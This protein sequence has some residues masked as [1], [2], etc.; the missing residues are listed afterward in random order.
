MRD[1]EVY[2]L[3]LIRYE[4]YPLGK[5]ALALPREFSIHGGELESL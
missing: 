2:T 1:L 4:A 3:E 5:E